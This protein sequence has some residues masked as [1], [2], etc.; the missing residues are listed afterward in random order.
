MEMDKR[1][2]SLVTVYVFVLPHTIQASTVLL[3]WYLARPYVRYSGITN[4]A[5]K[6]EY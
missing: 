6:P 4:K 3:D 5:L 2:F 1:S